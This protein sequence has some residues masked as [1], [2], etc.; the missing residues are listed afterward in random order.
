MAKYRSVI[1]LLVVTAAV[2]L[3][4]A[5]PCSANEGKE[6][7]KSLF[8]EP[9]PRGRRPWDWRIELTE[10]E[11]GRILESLKKENL[12]AANEL[13]K[14]REQAPEKFIEELRRN[15]GPEYEKIVEEHRERARRQRRADF[16]DWLEKN[17]RRESRELAS[18]KDRDPNL[19][20]KRLDYFMREKYAP[21][22]EAERSNPELAVV[23]KED[24]LLKERRDMLV[25]K[26]PAAKN[27]RDK[28]RLVAQLESVVAER[29]DLILRRKQIE[30]ERLLRWLEA[31]QKRIE[32]SRAEIAEAKKEE[33]KA[34]N[35]KERMK[36]LLE[37]KK[38]FPW[39]D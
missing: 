31:L 10:E 7:D 38:K 35:V 33:V 29:Y 21:I 25:M 27:E 36:T 2:T 1:L 4:A 17:Y 13:V 26:I 23:L 22:R 18:V 12:K 3:T 32:R 19:Y 39:G 28:Q 16:L 9:E 30:F 11:I 24:L 15:G 37:G 6:D 5:L 34:E 14:L 20:E 8:N